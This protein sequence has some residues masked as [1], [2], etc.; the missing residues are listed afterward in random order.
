MTSEK[1][2][3]IYPANKCY[4]CVIANMEFKYMHKK[5]HFSN[6]RTQFLKEFDISQRSKI[7]FIK[8]IELC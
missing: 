8:K 1:R 7:G 4:H 3:K 5:T 6:K 2:Q